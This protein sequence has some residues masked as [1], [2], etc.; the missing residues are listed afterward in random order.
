ME[1]LSSCHVII[2]ITFQRG[3]IVLQSVQATIK[4]KIIDDWLM[5]GTL[6][7]LSINQSID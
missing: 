1:G 5:E 2:G 4:V 7:Y 6:F 3:W